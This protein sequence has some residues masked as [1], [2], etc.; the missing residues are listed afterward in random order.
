MIPQINILAAVDVIGAFRS[1]TL[2]GNCYL[3]DNSRSDRTSGQGSLQLSSAVTYGQV[4]NWQVMPID[5]QTFVEI[6]NI[7][8]F[9]SA[10]DQLDA[11]ADIPCAKLK[12]YGAPSGDY[13]AGI[14]G[15]TIP[16]GLYYYQLELD[17]GRK[18]MSTGAVSSIFV[19]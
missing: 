3:M 14:V 4:I 13:W 12:K 8:F 5:L 19:E 7:L 11:S 18:V 1:G 16:G 17:M 15:A 2:E 9:D 6:K 10:G